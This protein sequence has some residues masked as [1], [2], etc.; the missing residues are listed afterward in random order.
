M[1][2]VNNHKKMKKKVLKS[3][4]TRKKKSCLKTK[5]KT[6]RKSRKKNDDKFDCS[7]VD[8]LKLRSL[9]SCLLNPNYAIICDF[10]IKF[11]DILELPT[12]PLKDLQLM[13]GR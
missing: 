4:V 6:T 2:N 3:F 8:E 9:D 12:V 7:F 10:L 11:S 13:I 5:L 1:L